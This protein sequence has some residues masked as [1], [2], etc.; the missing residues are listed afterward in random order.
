MNRENQKS[1]STDELLKNL[2]TKSPRETQNEKKHVTINVS[3]ESPAT[4][5]NKSP[6]SCVVPEKSP[7]P[8]R[9]PKASILK[10]PSQTLVRS[11]KESVSF[12][13][14]SLEDEQTDKRSANIKPDQCTPLLKSISDTS[15]L[16]DSK[17]SQ[18]KLSFSN[19]DSLTQMKTP[20]TPKE[21]SPTRKPE[22]P[23]GRK[24]SDKSRPTSSKH[25][26]V[27]I[28]PIQ[29]IRSHKQDSDVDSV[30]QFPSQGIR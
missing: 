5:R 13:R 3:V 20:K 29:G 26:S 15:T 12:E 23:H 4:K 2:T 27:H 22:T 6:P 10:N 30:K 9:Q 7:S 14:R 8:T 19:S 25:S 24:D 17:T 18:D 11:S 1:M 21:L 28:P 16:K